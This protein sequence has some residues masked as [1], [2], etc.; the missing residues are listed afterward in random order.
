MY[1][2]ENRQGPNQGISPQGKHVQKGAGGETE[3][4]GGRSGI[5]ILNTG[6]LGK[7]TQNNLAED[8]GK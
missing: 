7:K 4:R 1:L 6:E 8:K 3:V 5:H 2:L